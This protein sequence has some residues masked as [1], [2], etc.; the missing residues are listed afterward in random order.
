MITKVILKK[1]IEEKKQ[2]PEVRSVFSHKIVSETNPLLTI[3]Q[4][5]PENRCKNMIVRTKYMNEDKTRY[6]TN[7]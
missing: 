3:K 1:N 6:L 4:Q 2:K 5:L 7:Y